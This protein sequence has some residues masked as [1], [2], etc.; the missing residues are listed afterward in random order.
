MEPLF[1]KLLVIRLCLLCLSTFVSGN[2]FASTT[3]CQNLYI[4]RIWLEKGLGLKAV[5][6][7]NNRG[8]SS[9]SYWS[10]FTGW[11]ADDKNVLLSSLMLAK[12]ANHRVNVETENADKCGLQAGG[13]I[14]KALYLTTNP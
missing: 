1:M 3:D 6:Y 2:V 14:T 9:G 7:L 10:Y 11:T 13:T 4:G 5:V 12:A 8:D